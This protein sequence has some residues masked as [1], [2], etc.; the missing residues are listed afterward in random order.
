MKT[1]ISRIFD[2]I[3]KNEKNLKKK[4]IYIR[5]NTVNI[6]HQLMHLFINIY[7][8]ASYKNYSPNISNI[9]RPLHKKRS[10]S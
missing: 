2:S 10:E 4:R 5:Q 3:L 8:K 6:D 1:M 7:N 9:I